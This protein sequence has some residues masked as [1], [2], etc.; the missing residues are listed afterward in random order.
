MTP[1]LRERLELVLLP[2]AFGDGL[3]DS[4]SQLGG[5]GSTSDQVLHHVPGEGRAFL[6][7][8]SPHPPEAVEDLL[9]EVHLKVRPGPELLDGALPSF[10]VGLLGF[11]G[12]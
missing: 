10:K 11:A 7:L 12:Q 1:Q 2:V 4:E 5:G 9:G 8:V 6:G 3:G